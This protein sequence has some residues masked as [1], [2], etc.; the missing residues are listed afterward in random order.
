MYIV[1]SFGTRWL[2]SLCHK[3]MSCYRER[4]PQ[5]WGNFIFSKRAYK[6][7]GL[8]VIYNVIRIT[9]HRVQFTEKCLENAGNH[10]FK[11]AAGTLMKQALHQEKKK[12]CVS[13]KCNFSL[14]LSFSPQ[15]FW[16]KDYS[17]DFYFYEVNNLMK[18]LGSAGRTYVF[19]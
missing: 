18:I 3:Y 17:V 19:L 7:P 1:I 8:F 9:V 4:L 11:T 10:L 13:N 14:F 5:K 16:R 6:S 2:N 15:P 12:L